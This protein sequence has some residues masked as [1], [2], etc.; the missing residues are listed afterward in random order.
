[1]ETIPLLE[2][3]KSVILDPIIG[4]LWFLALAYFFYG[5]FEFI[6][7]ADDSGARETG[8]QHLIWGV[9]GLFIMTGVFGLIRLV[10]YSVGATC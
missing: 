6:R 5:L 7:H 4:L 3:V 2:K 8:R 9:I 10:C 1:M